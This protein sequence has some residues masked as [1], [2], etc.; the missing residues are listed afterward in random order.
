M[1][2]YRRSEQRFA[3][4][5]LINAVTGEVKSEE[6]HLSGNAT[7][8]E[9]EFPGNPLVGECCGDLAET[10]SS[11][12]F[13]VTVAEGEYDAR[14]QVQIGSPADLRGRRALLEV[15]CAAYSYSLSC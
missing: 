3:P 15:L 10:S 2:R 7:N 13:V 8:Q 11:G 5:L 6:I 14:S 1:R 12:V 4:Q 9:L